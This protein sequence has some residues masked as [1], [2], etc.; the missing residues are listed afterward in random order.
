MAL[1]S[2]QAPVSGVLCTTWSYPGDGELLLSDY[3]INVSPPPDLSAQNTSHATFTNRK[4][5]LSSVGESCK[6]EE[7]L[8]A[9]P[10]VLRALY[11]WRRPWEEFSP[12]ETMPDM[13]PQPFPP[14]AV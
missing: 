9:S 5:L 2:S 1:S 7:P 13:D 6:A 14:F 12:E 4:G 11:I 8:S 3:M 10:R